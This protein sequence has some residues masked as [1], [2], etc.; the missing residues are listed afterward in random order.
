MI[1]LLNSHMASKKD[2]FSE[3]YG[4]LIRLYQS[5]V[6]IDSIII[7]ILVLSIYYVQK[8]PKNISIPKKFLISFHFGDNVKMQK[9]IVE[10][11]FKKWNQIFD[12][13]CVNY[14]ERIL[15]NLI[16]ALSSRVW[17]TSI[18]LQP[19]VNRCI[20]QINVT[21]KEIWN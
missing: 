8:V 21:K 20:V 13:F 11:L 5:Y 1:I 19:Y 2:N 7:N 4:L 17:W 15:E 16:N 18:F 14:H 6:F 3:I 10:E 12:D 9:T